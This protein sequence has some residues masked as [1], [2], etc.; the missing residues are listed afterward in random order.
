MSTHRAK[1]SKALKPSDDPVRSCKFCG[2]TDERAC[3]TGCTWVSPNV[4]L[5]DACIELLM[6]A[7]DHF[8]RVIAGLQRTKAARR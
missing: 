7:L 5:C 2:C 8:E 6:P 3:P 4:D 1:R